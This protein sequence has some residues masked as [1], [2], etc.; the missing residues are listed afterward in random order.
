M[1]GRTVNATYFEPQI[2]PVL[3]PKAASEY[4][5][6][7]E[8]TLAH[9]R[10]HGLPPRFVRLAANRVGYLRSDLDKFLLSSLRTST[11]DEGECVAA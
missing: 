9:R 2:G 10:C 5:G 1:S 11:A 6:I 3:K 8:K 4:T 7:S